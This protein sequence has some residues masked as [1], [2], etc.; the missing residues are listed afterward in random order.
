MR[1]GSR[2]RSRS[3]ERGH[4]PR[5]GGKRRGAGRARGRGRGRDSPRR[6]GRDSLRVGGLGGESAGLPGRRSAR[7]VSCALTVRSS[8]SP[9]AVA[10]RPSAS[11]RRS[12]PPQW[13]AFSF[14]AMEAVT[15]LLSFGI[16]IAFLV[17]ASG[18]LMKDG[19]SARLIFLLPGGAG[20]RVPRDGGAAVERCAA[21]VQPMRSEAH[22][23]RIR[24]VLR[25]QLRDAQPIRGHP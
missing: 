12:L 6:A 25:V 10:G 20:H 24:N 16:S 9:C 14:G 22:S 1:P 11:P 2:S 17:V 13:R 18:R 4:S 21:G 3:R 8:S 7:P 5:H 23:Q 15:D 19:G